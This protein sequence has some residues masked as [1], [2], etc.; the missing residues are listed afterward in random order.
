MLTGN[1]D[2]RS[3]TDDQ[4]GDSPYLRTFGP[5][6]FRTTNG[7]LLAR[8]DPTPV[9]PGLLGRTIDPHGPIRHDPGNGGPWR[10]TWFY[11]NPI[12]VDVR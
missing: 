7:K 9:D 5:S 2:I 11:P 4:R 8:T 10:D 3:N 1:H 12:F 6:R